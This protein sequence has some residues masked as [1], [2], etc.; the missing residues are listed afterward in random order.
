MS[1]AGPFCS[2]CGTHMLL[3]RVLPDRPGYEKQTYKCS[4]CPEEMTQVCRINESA[5]RLMA[6]KHFSQRS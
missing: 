2:Q 3:V 1:A 6:K 4:W 5:L